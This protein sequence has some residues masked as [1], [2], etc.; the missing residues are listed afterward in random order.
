MADA[1][2]SRSGRGWD[3]ELTFLNPGRKMRMT[4]GQTDRERRQM[5]EIMRRIAA[6][7]GKTPPSSSDEDT[8]PKQESGDE[9]ARL[10]TQSD[11]SGKLL[12]KKRKKSKSKVAEKFRRPGID[13]RN[14]AGETQVMR[15]VHDADL[16]RV[17]E[18]I[19]D[20][21]DVNITCNAGWTPLHESANPE[22]TKLLLDA[23]AD[24]NARGPEGLGETATTTLHE[25]ARHGNT[26]VVKVLLEYYADPSIRNSEGKLPIDL[27][28]SDSDG[29]EIK[30]I[31]TKHVYK[32][33]PSPSTSESDFG[34]ELETKSP[35]RVKL[36]SSNKAKKPAKK[37]SIKRAESK[38]STSQGKYKTPAYVE[39][40]D[41]EDEG[42][43][44]KSKKSKTQR[45]TA[46]RKTPVVKKKTKGTSVV[47]DAESSSSSDD[48]P[49]NLRNVSKAKVSSPDNGVES[50]KKEISP[51]ATTQQQS[52]ASQFREAVKRKAKS[53]K[54]VDSESDV[55]DEVVSPKRASTNKS[56]VEMHQKQDRYPAKPAEKVESSASAAE[57]FVKPPISKSAQ[58]RIE[59]LAD[60]K[61]GN[62]T[63]R[64]HQ[65]LDA[66]EKKKV[67]EEP[68]KKDPAMMGPPSITMQPEDQTIFSGQQV[69]YYIA[70]TGQPPLRFQ[71][72]QGGVRLSNAPPEVLSDKRI[73]E[74]ID[75]A[76]RGLLTIHNIRSDDVRCR[77][78]STPRVGT[79]PLT[80]TVSNSIG[81]MKSKP[82]RLTVK[83][84]P[85]EKAKLLEKNHSEATDLAAALGLD[86]P[87]PLL[88]PKFK[89]IPTESEFRLIS[90]ARLALNLWTKKN[91]K[92]LLSVLPPGEGNE[93]GPAKTS[94]ASS[95]FVNAKSSSNQQS[96]W[97]PP[98]TGQ[99]TQSQHRPPPHHQYY[100][101]PR[102]Q[103]P[104]PPPDSQ[105][106]VSQGSGRMLI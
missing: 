34:S 103:P 16:T 30:G 75:G 59:M 44:K 91:E 55:G 90:D 51:R 58:K 45:K 42:S 102:Q 77:R 67:K 62:R 25:A 72:Y 83:A 6:A 63:E 56:K 36:S 22:I 41:I 57:K 46:P 78:G 20:G 31:L 24:P 7:E 38:S 28:D 10:R 26:E 15:A 87:E 21:A 88:L 98:K 104:P 40:S 9:A 13:R 71:W 93:S 96:R 84:S 2:K 94:S 106:R 11:Q 100:P 82:A 50:N 12:T 85:A 69:I 86:P 49:I 61:K 18:L 80:C 43:P 95:N 92:M 47:K 35:K 53:K 5:K 1:Q 68:I 14:R 4:E 37:V 65:K 54:L 105:R 3:N 23:E 99:G 73:Y 19:A 52:M 70:A 79:E 66:G 89:P 8:K 48:E 39:D 32:P 17:K 27:V 64:P 81:Q 97:G 33:P 76:T 29:E 101:P 60:A 74:R